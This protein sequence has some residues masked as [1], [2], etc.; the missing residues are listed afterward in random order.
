MQKLK[1]FGCYDFYI[2]GR[3]IAFISLVQN[4]VKVAVSFGFVVWA[5][6]EPKNLQLQNGEQKKDVNRES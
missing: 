3:I 6:Q 2:G 5:A 1:L 4:F